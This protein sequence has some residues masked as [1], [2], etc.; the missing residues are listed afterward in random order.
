MSD[1]YEDDTARLGE[2]PNPEGFPCCPKCGEFV[3]LVEDDLDHYY[4][5]ECDYTFPLEEAK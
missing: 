2:D 5:G 4:C 3:D 1:S